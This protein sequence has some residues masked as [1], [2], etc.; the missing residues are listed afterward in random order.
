MKIVFVTISAISLVAGCLTLK[1]QSELAKASAM[2]LLRNVGQKRHGRDELCQTLRAL[3]SE[4]KAKASQTLKNAW[5]EARAGGQGLY[6]DEYEPFLVAVGDNEIIE[7]MVIAHRDNYD[8]GSALI[9]SGNPDVVTRM[10]D[11]LLA[12]NKS[13]LLDTDTPALG[14]AGSAWYVIHK[15]LLI[16][17]EF[18]DD[19]KSWVKNGSEDVD[20]LEFAEEANPR[21]EI[22]R[23]WWKANRT[24]F[25]EK[26]YSLVK[27]GEAW[28]VLEPE[29]IIRHTPSSTKKPE[30]S[31]SRNPRTV[32]TQS[33]S[34]LSGVANL[35]RNVFVWIFIAVVF[36]SAA[37]WMYFRFRRKKG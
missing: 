32:A 20:V 12:D 21:V 22:L 34:F 3:S 11:E 2:E 30:I 35:L 36:A 26:K 8:R 19:L 29:Q 24:L 27:P 1:A 14:V 6:Y 10:G 4:D 18:S 25:K 17:P 9:T 5:K 23:V 16:A 28:P 33:K 7:S 31:E 13:R 37:G 15:I